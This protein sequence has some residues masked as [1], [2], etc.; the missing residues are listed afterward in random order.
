[1]GTAII[2]ARHCGRKHGCTCGDPAG[3]SVA[4]DVHGGGDLYRGPQCRVY[5]HV[6]GHSAF[7]G[8]NRLELGLAVWGINDRRAVS[9][10]FGP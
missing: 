6:S 8:R 7:D 3:Y 9:E 4:Q 5:G 10:F 1:M 2:V